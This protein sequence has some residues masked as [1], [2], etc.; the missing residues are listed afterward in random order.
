MFA[1]C[2]TVQT[3]KF[4]IHLFF[5]P[6]LPAQCQRVIGQVRRISVILQSLVPSNRSCVS[7]MTGKVISLIVLLFFRRTTKEVIS[8]WLNLNPIRSM[9]STRG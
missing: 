4:P 2:P 3:I 8:R 1:Y 9:S 5:T 7:L 6:A